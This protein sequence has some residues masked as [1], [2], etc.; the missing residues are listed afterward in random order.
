MPRVNASNMYLIL[1][2]FR[3]METDIW[4]TFLSQP[5]LLLL[6][7]QLRLLSLAQLTSLFG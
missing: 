5:P 4:I 6:L 1:P 3:L 2:Q 7:L